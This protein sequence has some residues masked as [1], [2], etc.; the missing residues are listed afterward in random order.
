MRFFFCACLLFISWELQARKTGFKDTQTGISM[1]VGTYQ[2]WLP[3]DNAYDPVPA[4]ALAGTTTKDSDKI[5]LLPAKFGMFIHTGRT[6]I[7]GYFRYMLNTRHPWSAEGGINGTGHITFRSYGGG[8]NLGT[9]LAQSNRAQINLVLNGEYILQRARLDFTDG[10]TAQKL[11]LAST[12]LLAGAGLQ[13]EFWLG[14][15]WVLS[16]FAGYQYG[17]LRNWDVVEAANFMGAARSK[18]PLID[19]NGNKARSQFGGFLFEL[20]LKLNFYN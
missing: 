11:Q 20:A 9:S 2:H 16:L 4:L 19:S 12:S 17:F 13:P 15:L 7:E 8:L 5:Y 14:D 3:N 1:G 10:S 6:Q 18:G